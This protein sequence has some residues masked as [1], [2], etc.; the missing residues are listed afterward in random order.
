[1]ESAKTPILIQRFF[2]T[3]KTLELDKE[4]IRAQLYY[5]LLRELVVG[6]FA[7]SYMQMAKWVREGK[8]P[9][10]AS[11]YPLTIEEMK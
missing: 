4:K 8:F 9:L 11:N 5:R 10:S 7:T 6:G 3:K 2:G 1:M